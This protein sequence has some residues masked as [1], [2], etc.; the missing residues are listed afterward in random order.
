MMVGRGAEELTMKA[1]AEGE[2]AMDAVHGVTEGE[3][4]L[5][6]FKD[7]VFKGATSGPGHE[8]ERKMKVGVG[9]AWY[10]FSKNFW[11]GGA[12]NGFASIERV[13]GTE[14]PGGGGGRKEYQ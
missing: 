3:E 1:D 9:V 5:L 6:P 8:G 11:G 12:D 13:H 7:P 10:E 14:V 4:A 2:V